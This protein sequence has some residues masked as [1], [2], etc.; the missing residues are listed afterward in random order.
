VGTYEGNLSLSRSR[1]EAVVEA[2]V[3]RHDIARN[4]AVPAGV[5]P[6]APMASNAT[7]AG[8]AENRRVELVAR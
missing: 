8:R 5:G 6:L 3:S 7:E 4:R 1:A 2:L